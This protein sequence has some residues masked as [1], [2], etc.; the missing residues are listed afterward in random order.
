MESNFLTLSCGH[1]D[2]L[3]L[4]SRFII[5]DS[6]IQRIVLATEEAMVTQHVSHRPIKC[7][8]RS[9]SQRYTKVNGSHMVTTRYSNQQGYKLRQVP[10]EYNHSRSLESTF[11]RQDGV[12]GYELQ[13]LLSGVLPVFQNLNYKLP[14]WPEWSSR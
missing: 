9:W 2:R 3:G 13:F 12:F 10:A 7:Q 11:R 14:A 5:A 4:L 6:H 1:E 8:S